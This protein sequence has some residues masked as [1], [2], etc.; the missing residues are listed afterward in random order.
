[1]RLGTVQKRNAF[2]LVEL[3]VVI[4]IIVLLM[5]MTLGVMTK[6]WQYTDESR[7]QVDISKLAEA[8]GQFKGQFGRIPP[9]KI[10]LCE[11]PLEWNQIMGGS[12]LPPPA[13]GLT[14]AQFAQ[15]GASSVE[16]LTSIFPGINLNVPI[17]WNGSPSAVPD[18][19]IILEGE[20]CLVYFLG[21]MRYNSSGPTG[22]NTDKSNPTA[23]TNTQRLGPFFDFK[24]ERIERTTFP[25]TAFYPTYKD[26]Y[27][28]PYAYFAGR[29]ASANNY[30]NA[31]L[32]TNAAVPG[33]PAP[34]D[35]HAMTTDNSA[36]S[37][38]YFVPY[39]QGTVPASIPIPPNWAV[40]VSF[41][42]F[43]GDSFQIISAGKDKRFGTGGNFNPSD[44]ENSPFMPTGSILPGLLPTAEMIK[45]NFDNL[46][47]FTSG[48]M[49]PQ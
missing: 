4:A 46:T 8:I 28:T 37:P 47:N 10:I 49:V 15:L 42:F 22:F 17:N 3:L 1:M 24:E 48:R 16:Y 41:Q 35:C 40:A 21:G 18:P 29:N 12:I 13:S 32:P 45:Q 30:P 11:N 2:T 6:V 27:G 39:F 34:N 25:A 44:P 38:V 5:A 23:Q 20:Q 7:T 19:Y 9:G 36:G 43:K 26:H 31:Y 33:A 14:P